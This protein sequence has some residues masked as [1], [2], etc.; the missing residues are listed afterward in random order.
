MCSR[1]PRTTSL[2]LSVLFVDDISVSVDSAGQEVTSLCYFV[3]LCHPQSQ[4]VSFIW[5]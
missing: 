1:P 2:S 5:F 3:A 4:L